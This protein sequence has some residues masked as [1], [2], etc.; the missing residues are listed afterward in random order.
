[1]MHWF[2]NVDRKL[3]EILGILRSVHN[4]GAHMSA[5][6]DALEAQVT[7]MT[8][9]EKSAVALI[10][11]LAAQIAAAGTD[12]AKLRALTASLQADAADLS[13]AITANTPAAP[14]P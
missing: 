5:E 11:G 9:V 10:N 2:R 3:D 13:A 12:P 4:Q 1:M 14:T 6:M 8:T 7:Q